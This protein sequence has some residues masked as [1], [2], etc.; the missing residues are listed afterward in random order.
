MKP[1]LLVEASPRFGRSLSRAAGEQVVQRLKIREPGL[2][3]L[4]RDLV[5][6]APPL[7]DE[8]FTEA[9]YV[10]AAQQDEMQRRALAASETMI[11]ELEDSGAL[12]IST[13]MH[14]FTVPAVLKAWIDQVLRFDRTFRRTPQGKVGPLADRPT[15]VV[16]ATGGFITGERARQPD[17]LTPYLQA[18]L[19]TLGIRTVRFLYLEAFPG[20]SDRSMDAVI[21]PWL[22]R[23]LPVP[24]SMTGA[25]SS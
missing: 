22:D 14:N 7:V 3:I 25:L 18:V 23:H 17:F 15:H 12:V 1:L 11:A 24:C 8:A 21:Q 9:M 10:P 5:A 4:R 16:V 2:P 6:T 13:P 20:G 19:A